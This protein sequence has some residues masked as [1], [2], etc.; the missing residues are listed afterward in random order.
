MKVFCLVFR[1]ISK[2]NYYMII[3]ILI[4]K[5]NIYDK[6]EVQSFSSLEVSVVFGFLDLNF[7]PAIKTLIG[8]SISIVL[9]FL[10]FS[11]FFNEPEKN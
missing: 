6:I 9:L 11:I 4:I 10:N 7:A 3:N 1:N 2:S 5:L 8:P